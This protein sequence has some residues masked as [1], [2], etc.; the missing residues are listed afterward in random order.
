METR[1]TDK[2][3]QEAFG[4][5]ERFF[6]DFLASGRRSGYDEDGGGGYRYAFW[7]GREGGVGGGRVLGEGGATEG[8][9]HI[10]HCRCPL[11]RRPLCLC[12]AVTEHVGFS[13][14]HCMRNRNHGTFILLP[15]SAMLP[16]GQRHRV[17]AVELLGGKPSTTLTH[18]QPN[19]KRTKHC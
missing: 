4:S 15:T 9:H 13:R 5:R 19:T 14:R 6:E 3:F 10:I 11:D 18:K 2:A 17:S 8:N 7:G 12:N 16:G 1:R